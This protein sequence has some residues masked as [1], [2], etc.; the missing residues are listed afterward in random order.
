MANP[1]KI[2]R[3]ELERFLTTLGFEVTHVRG[4][5]RVYRRKD[6]DALIVLPENQYVSPHHLV[7]VKSTLANYDI[8]SQEEFDAAMMNGMHAV[9]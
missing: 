9:R 1:R 7:A 2:T 4:S 5:H 6:G 8:M 3:Q